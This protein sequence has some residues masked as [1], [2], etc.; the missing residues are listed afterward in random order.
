MD[1]FETAGDRLRGRSGR[2]VTNERV[3]LGARPVCRQT[4]R[5]SLRCFGLGDRLRAVRR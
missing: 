5:A 3:A 2:H 1:L 4:E